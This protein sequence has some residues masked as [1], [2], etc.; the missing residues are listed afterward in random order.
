MEKV[1][2]WHLHPESSTMLEPAQFV[3]LKPNGK[4]VVNDETMM[5]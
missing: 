1:L 5:M 2:H 3:F 4:V